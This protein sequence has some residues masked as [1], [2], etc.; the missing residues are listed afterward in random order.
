MTFDLAPAG[1]HTCKEHPDTVGGAMLTG[2]REAVRVFHML[3]GED[4]FGKAAAALVDKDAVRK[5][6]KA[7]LI[8]TCHLFQPACTVTSGQLRGGW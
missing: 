6:K 2:L 1:E 4:A 8:S 7:S 3:K 5:R